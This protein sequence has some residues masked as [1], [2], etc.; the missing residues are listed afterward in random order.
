MQWPCQ[1][2][3]G[4]FLKTVSLR[5][6]VYLV[7]EEV[8]YNWR[9]CFAFVS[10]RKRRVLSQEERGAGGA[11]PPTPPLPSLLRARRSEE[12]VERSSTPPLPYLEPG[13]ARSLEERSSPPYL[14]TFWEMW[15]GTLEMWYAPPTIEV[16][17]GAVRTIGGAM[18]KTGSGK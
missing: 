12:Q 18:K 1:R 4:R 14:G 15:Y 5:L 3:H 6:Y 9:K 16:Q 17:S 10:S 13:G 8:I 7:F 2:L 11:A